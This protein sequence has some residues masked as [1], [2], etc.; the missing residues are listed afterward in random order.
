MKKHQKVIFGILHF[1]PDSTYSYCN[2][3]EMLNMYQTSSKVMIVGISVLD[4]IP[5]IFCTVL[6]AN[7]AEP[8]HNIYF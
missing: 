7:E 5:D 1:S 8:K 4:Y 2:V 6:S 3:L